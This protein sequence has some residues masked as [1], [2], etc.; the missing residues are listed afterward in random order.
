MDPVLTKI[1]RLIIQRQYIFTEK[2]DIER[3]ADGLSEEDVLE[4]ILN[5]T[6]VRIKNSRSAWRAGRR[7]KTYILESFTYDGVLIYSKG[8]IR[9]QGDRQVL[10]IVVS[11]KKSTWED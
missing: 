7:E 8:V 10:Y 11:A 2:A 5:A 6:F 4:S 9:G 1:K 3:I